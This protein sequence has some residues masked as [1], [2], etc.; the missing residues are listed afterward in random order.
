MPYGKKRVFSVQF[1]GC[2]IYV[3]VMISFFILYWYRACVVLW[4]RVSIFYNRV[5][6]DFVCFF[7]LFLVCVQQFFCTSILEYSSCTFLY[8][9]FFQMQPHLWYKKWVQSNAWK[10]EEI[11]FKLKKNPQTCNFTGLS[12]S[13]LK[14]S[15][16]Y[17]PTSLYISIVMESVKIFF[18]LDRTAIF[19][20][21]FCKCSV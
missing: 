18:L 11:I 21:F 7:S 20:F 3:T 4:F 15:L 12:N 16:K 2:T 9:L 10:S 5:V 19:F 8:L 1:L 6:F 13:Y 17:F 14:Y